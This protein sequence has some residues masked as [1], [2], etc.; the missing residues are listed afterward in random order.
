MMPPKKKPES[1][2]SRLQGTSAFASIVKRF[3]ASAITLATEKKVDFVPRLSSNV[4]QLDYAL[5]GGWPIGRISLVYGHKS[6]GKSTLMT[7]AAASAQKTCGACY[8]RP[9]PP[10][11]KCQCGDFREMSVV[12]IDVEGSFAGDWGRNLGCDPEQMLLARPDYA[13]QA[14]DI[15][16]ALIRSQECDVIIL[17]SI[18]FLTPAKE[19]EES[20]AKDHMGT[21]ARISGKAV[22]K[23]NAAMNAVGNEQ[24]GWKPTIFLVNQIRMKIGLL[25]GNPETQPGGLAWGFAASNEVKV[26]GGKYKMDEHSGRPLY[27][28][29]DF[30]V[31]KNKTGVPKM[32]G[33]IRMMLSDTEGKKK[34]QIADEPFIVAQLER[35][36][37]LTGHGSSWK[38]GDKSFKGKKYI[39]QALISDEEFN[40]EIRTM[41]MTVL[42]AS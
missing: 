4:F 32:E 1:R 18:A 28:D 3:G 23:F 33:E 37:L 15:L 14:L 30:K 10:E 42:L 12:Y 8:T 7:L 17:D 40:H 20:V 19:I 21:Q 6:T 24:A 38:L 11:G 22:R 13:E 26:K 34:G 41:L 9:G 25:F 35:L 16:E 2:I 31:D 39:E 36:G 27:V 29:L 5:G